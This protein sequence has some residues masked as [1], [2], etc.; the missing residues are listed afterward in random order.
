MTHH[1]RGSWRR[2]GFVSVVRHR[3]DFEVVYYVDMARRA[4][5]RKGTETVTA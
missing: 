5:G 3:A 2:G 1:W 4:G